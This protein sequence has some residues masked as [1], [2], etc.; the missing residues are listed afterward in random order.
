MIEWERSAMEKIEG[1]MDGLG[2]WA[3]EGSGVIRS[4]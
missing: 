2:I 4:G 3:R 1:M